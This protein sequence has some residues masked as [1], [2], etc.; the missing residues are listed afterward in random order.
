MWAGP[1]SKCK[2]FV[3]NNTIRYDCYAVKTITVPSSVVHMYITRPLVHVL[4]AQKPPSTAIKYLD[5]VWQNNFIKQL[6]GKQ[7]ASFY[8]ALKNAST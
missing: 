6:L 5:Q 7:S 3:S 2:N 8:E 4:D 1:L